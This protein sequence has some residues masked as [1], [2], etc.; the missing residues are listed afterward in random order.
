[1]VVFLKPG[2][3]KST[4]L[5]SLGNSVRASDIQHHTTG[6]GCMM[7]L[8]LQEAVVM[9]LQGTVQRRWEVSGAVRHTVLVCG[10][11]LAKQPDIPLQ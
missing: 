5:G 2:V 4:R 9:A 3:L 6:V 8:A 7:D 10:V 1:M 11:G